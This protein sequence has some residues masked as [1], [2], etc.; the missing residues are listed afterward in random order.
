MKNKTILNHDKIDFDGQ[1]GAVVTPIFQNSLFGFESWDSIDKAFENPQEAYIYSR[2]HNPTSRIAEKKLADLAGAEDAKLTSSG[3]S[4]ISAA[5]LHFVKAGDHI[6]TVKN[7]YGPANVFIHDYLKEKCG[8]TASFVNGKSVKNIAKAIKS[9]TTLIYLESPTSMTFDLQDLSAIAEL[10]KKKG[11]KTI[12]DNT[13]SSPLFQKPLALGIDMEVHSAS[14]YLSGHSD[15]VA[16]LI[17]GKKSDLASILT[18]EHALLGGKMA[19]FESWLILRSLRTLHI[20]MKSLMKSSLKVAK[21]LEGQTLVSK[22]NYPGLKSHHQFELVTKQMSGYGCLLSFE[23][24]T[25]EIEKIKKFVNSLTLFHL[26]VSWGGHESLVYAPIISY[27]KELDPTQFKEMGIKP[28]LIRISIGLEDPKDLIKDLKKA[29][30]LLV[31]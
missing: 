26:G 16:G 30:K 31:K 25:T 8:I 23:L 9:N 17:L 27:A 28:G 12:I 18:K 22:V 19:P 3:M 13:Y 15:V 7:I 6:V 14:K 10:A 4:A 29:L 20:R 11:I 5:I 2:L 24:K 21:W 1:H